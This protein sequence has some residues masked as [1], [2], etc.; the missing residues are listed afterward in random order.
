M[1]EVL[2]VGILIGI[3]LGVAL[4]RLVLKATLLPWLL[5]HGWR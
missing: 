2:L 1:N 5:S 3:F 4:D